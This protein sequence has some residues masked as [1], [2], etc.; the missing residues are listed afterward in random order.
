MK[1]STKQKKNKQQN[2]KRQQKHQQGKTQRPHLQAP[3]KLGEQSASVPDNVELDG[4]VAEEQPA[5]DLDVRGLNAVAS[6]TA[7]ERQAA[8]LARQQRT[9]WNQQR[10]AGKMAGAH[11]PKRFN[12][13]G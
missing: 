6:P 11:V 3:A 12:R 5:P 8:L 10:K 2:K 9:Q 7:A 13:G 4:I 1:K